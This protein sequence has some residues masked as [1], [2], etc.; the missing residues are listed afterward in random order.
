MEL[1]VSFQFVMNGVVTGLFYGLLAVGLSVVFGYL[2]LCNFTHGEFYMLGGYFTYVLITFLG[3]PYFLALPLA[4]VAVCIL[5]LIASLLIVQPLKDRPFLYLFMATFGLGFVFRESALF[6]W[7]GL[8][9]RLDSPLLKTLRFGGLYLLQQNLLISI[10]SVLL[11]LGLAFFIRN[12]SLG[13]QMRA[14]NQNRVGAALVGINI[15]SVY[16]WTFLIGCAL[17]AVAGIL[18]GPIINLVPTMGE[19][20]IFKAFIIVIIGG[21]GSILGSLVGGLILGIVESLAAAYISEAFKGLFGFF[22]AIFIL[23]VRPEGLFRR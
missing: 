11:L 14:I 16:N 3:I 9:Q 19:M 5:A 12:A 1:P 15:S 20:A 10:V 17:A 22:V 23:A 7:G 8:P 6:I 21:M 18:I 2:H 13:K 4:V